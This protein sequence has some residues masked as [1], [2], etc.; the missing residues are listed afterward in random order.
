MPDYDTRK[1]MLARD[2]LACSDGFR[3]LVLLT[4]KHL[5]GMRFCPHCP[6]CACTD[7]PCMDAFG[8]NATAMGGV[9]GRVDAV[10]GSIECQK[11]GTLHGHFQ[12][13]AQCFH[14]F[15]PLSDLL[16]LDDQR[17]LELLRKYTAYSAHVRRTIYCDPESWQ[18]QQKEVE[19]EW[20]EYR[21]SLL[22]V[23]RPGYQRQRNGGADA[24]K[25]AY[26]N[27]DVEQLQ[28]RKQHHVHLPDGPNGE[29][30]PLAHCRDPKDPTKCKS[31]FPRD[32]WLTDETFVVCPAMAEQLGMPHK[33]KRSMIGLAWG[34]CNDGSLNGHHPALLA[35]LRCNGDVQVPYRFPITHLSHHHGCADNCDEKVP[36]WSL[37]REAQ[38][39]QAAQTGYQCDYQNKRLPICRHEAKEWEK[40]QQ[41]L[42]QGLDDKKPGYVGARLVKRMIT[43][44]Y[45]RGVCRGAVEC[46]NLVLQSQHQDPLNAE[47]IRTAPVADMALQYPMH[48]FRCV[49]ERE[50]WPTEPRRKQVD[51]RTKSRKQLLDCPF[52]TLYGARGRWSELHLLSAYEFHHYYDFKLAKHPRSFEAHGRDGH[53]PDKYHAKLTSSG[54]AKVQ[55][56]NLGLVPAIDY[57]I[58][59]EGGSDWYPLAQS[60]LAQAYRHDWIIARRNRPHVPV[61]YGALGS[62]TEDEQALRLL[63]LFFPWANEEAD[64]SPE[65][66]SVHGM[67]ARAMG[68]WRHALRARVLCFGFPTEEIKRFALNFCFVYFL[69]RDL[70]LSE[71]L[72]ENSDNEALEDEEMAL[73]EADLLL[74]QHTHVRGS[75]SNLEGIDGEG[76]ATKLHD[77]T[78]DMFQISARLW[79]SESEAQC[80]AEEAE[81]NNAAILQRAA[82]TIDHRLAKEAARTS[83]SKLEQ[84]THEQAPGGMIPMAPAV[85]ERLPLSA[86]RLRQ[87][88]GSE[89]VSKGTNSQQHRFLTLVV[90]RILVECALVDPG[91]TTLQSAEPLVYL[92]HGP[93][94]T[95]KSF[96][97]SYLHELFKL[98]GYQQGIEY[99]VVAFQAVNAADLRGKTI[100]HAFGFSIGVAEAD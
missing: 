36:I 29:R 55:K 46:A 26:L 22:M 45:A 4:L 6:H 7:A 14:Q 79:L 10:Y 99:E 33:G 77:L 57:Q 27:E 16:K 20:P 17:H 97:L 70:Q 61:V 83:R 15:T 87:W 81:E 21:G 8:S 62:K 85:Q 72:V 44:C 95:G 2:P 82:A 98:V 68:D 9:S 40:G 18:D 66:P 30:R 39:N 50:A 52:W 54:E 34:P 24:W 35:G 89:H 11:S 59:E 19:D 73:S 65:V 69:P 38:I 90:E 56:Q 47:A 49:A 51:W 42:A 23:S 75:A 96:V 53:D 80:P 93:P 67:R 63:V 91:E 88:L 92:L 64:A 100:H 43:D 25:F 94:G 12:V 31:G 84:Q 13:F 86:A 1:A 71:G 78:M 48:L 76:G 58:L 32:R 5:L 37:M 28:Q 41:Q 74:A 3:T 60:T